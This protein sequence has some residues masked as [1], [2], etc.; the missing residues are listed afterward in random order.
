MKQNRDSNLDIADNQTWTLEH[1]TVFFHE[2][3]QSLTSSHLSRCFFPP[4]GPDPAPTPKML[5]GTPRHQLR[6]YVSQQ[7]ELEKQRRLHAAGRMGGQ[8]LV[9]AVTR[10]SLEQKAKWRQGAVTALHRVHQSG[11]FGR[12]RG[13]SQPH[14]LQGQ[15]AFSNPHSHHPP[16]PDLVRSLIYLC[17]VNILSQ[18]F[19]KFFYVEFWLVFV[20]FIPRGLNC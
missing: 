13:T 5:L 6:C 15:V 4:L 1:E 16:H 9:K 20:I 19:N 3:Y 11:G 17:L 18:S 10:H 2:M 7:Q 14:P 8:V 12:N